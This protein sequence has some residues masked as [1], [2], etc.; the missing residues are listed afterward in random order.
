MLDEKLKSAKQAAVCVCDGSGVLL[1]PSNESFSYVFTAKHVIEDKELSDIEVTDINGKKFTIIDKIEHINCDAA[2]LKVERHQDFNITY[3]TN[4]QDNT[5]NLMLFGFPK[6]KREHSTTSDSISSYS[7]N[8]HD[9][10]QYDST[11]IISE[12]IQNE[13]I[14]GFSGG[15]IYLANQECSALQL[16]AIQYEITNPNNIDSKVNGIK[17]D[18]FLELLDTNGWDK[19]EPLHISCFSYHQDFIFSKLE[20][21][22][23]K[24]VEGIKKLIQIMLNDHGV[25]GCEKLNPKN[26]INTF[27]DKILAFE[28]DEGL[29][30]NK[31]L[32]CAFLEFISI[33][34]SI[35]DKKQLILTNEDFLKYLFE[36]YR[37]IYDHDNTNIRQLFRKYIL[38]TDLDDLSERCKIIIFTQRNE[39]KGT[40]H[41]DKNVLVSTLSNIGVAL[42]DSNL[43]SRVEKNRTISNDVLHWP[44]INDVCMSSHED[45]LEVINA[46][47]KSPFF[48]I[49]IPHYEEYVSDNE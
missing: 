16:V 2:I 21:Q 26:I 32:W 24:S 12:D 37:L 39:N 36:N 40:A 30:N 33:L 4:F 35:G 42:N 17:V 14:Y 38:T 46:F 11:F 9:I 6:S 44:S 18:C 43:I 15:P 5:T 49:I 48:E 19:L 47:N 7:L 13:D 20:L 27:K 25:V 34:I 10:N 41:I 29:L 45:V 23:D 1:N 3:L 28:Q 31:E 8:L 22:N